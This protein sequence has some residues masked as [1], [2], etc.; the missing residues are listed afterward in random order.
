MKVNSSEKKERKEKGLMLNE[1]SPDPNNILKIKEL[2]ELTP[3]E[4]D[5][6]S[7]EDLDY[8]RQKYQV[9]HRCK[10]SGQMSSFNGRDNGP[11]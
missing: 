8:L 11:S 9:K 7:I 10:K 4:I 6:L 3:Q 1:L 2:N 5:D